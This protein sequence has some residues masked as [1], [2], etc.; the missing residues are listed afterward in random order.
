VVE[1]C[2][3]TGT[4]LA[5]LLEACT[6]AGLE[7]EW[8]GLELDPAPMQL[9]L[10]E[11]EFR[12]Q[13]HP[14]T[15]KTLE[16]LS[17]RGCWQQGCWQQGAGSGRILWGDAR[18]TLPHLLEQRR[19]QVDLVWHDAFSPQRCPQLWTVEVLGSL[20]ELLADGGRWISYCSA[21]AVREGLRLAHLNLAALATPNAG[22]SGQQRS[23]SGGT[24][25]SLQHLAP[26]VLWRP[27]SSMEL[28]HMGCSAGEPYRDPTSRANA[29]EIPEQRRRAQ[30]AALARGECSTSSAWRKRWGV[31]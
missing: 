28:E 8:W 26:S 19:G 18:Q 2:V 17:E 10:A 25:A 6:A 5:A 9:A 27:L 22:P 11:P 3:G 16:T 14:Q 7:L 1:V 23:W 4:N 15:L 30:A 24:V 21:A 29:A 31:K 13:W 20:A 12:S